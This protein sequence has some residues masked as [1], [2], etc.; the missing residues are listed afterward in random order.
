[1]AVL[2]GAL[3]PADRLN[4]GDSMYRCPFCQKAGY[5]AAHMFYTCLKLVT[6]RHPMIQKTQHLVEV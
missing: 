5:D 4:E 3:W 6:S 2:T 1:M